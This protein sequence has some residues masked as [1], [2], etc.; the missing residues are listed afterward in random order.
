LW[1]YRRPPCELRVAF[2]RWGETRG[3]GRLDAASLAAPGALRVGLVVDDEASMVAG[4]HLAPFS[5][6]NP[7]K[8]WIRPPPHHE[9]DREIEEGLGDDRVSR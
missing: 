7:R 3:G 5:C 1:G 4:L 9:K 2:T 8:I 6:R